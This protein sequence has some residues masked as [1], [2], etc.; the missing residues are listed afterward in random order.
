MQQY[1]GSSYL[2]LGP[3]PSPLPSQHYPKVLPSPKRYRKRYEREVSLQSHLRPF[4]SHPWHLTPNESEGDESAMNSD[5][6]QHN[7][8]C[9]VGRFAILVGHARPARRRVLPPSCGPTQAGTTPSLAFRA[10]LSGENVDLL[11]AL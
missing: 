7:P 11:V 8:T 2:L 6:D 5:R 10:M 1:D 4:I 3:V 9:S